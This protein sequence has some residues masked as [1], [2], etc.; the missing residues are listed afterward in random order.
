MVRWQVDP[1]KGRRSHDAGTA[2]RTGSTPDRRSNVFAVF[3]SVAN[4]VVDPYEAPTRRPASL[5][6]RDT[7]PLSIVSG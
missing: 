2:A 6:S 1:G 4:A 3:N 7:T 5:A